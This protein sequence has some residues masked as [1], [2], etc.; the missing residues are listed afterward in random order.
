MIAFALLLALAQD[1]PNE[2]EMFGAPPA[3]GLDAG[4]PPVEAA[5]P[6]PVA[7]DGGVNVDEQTLFGPAR[8]ALPGLGHP[9][10]GVG[11]RRPAEDER[12]HR[13]F[14]ESHRRAQ[15]AAA[16]PAAAVRFAAGR[17]RAEAAHSRREV[18]VEF[19]FVWAARHP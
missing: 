18:W 3:K 4:V 7:T 16:R 15:C 6:P 5:Q 13:T 14:V 12:G 1:R 2:D 19:L 11:S 10:H 17:Q 8:P 9:G